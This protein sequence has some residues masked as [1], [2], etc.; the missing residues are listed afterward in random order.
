MCALRCAARVRCA[1]QWRWLVYSVLALERV[2]HQALLDV[3]PLAGCESGTSC[4]FVWMKASEASI[5]LMDAF[6]S[7]LTLVLGLLSYGVYANIG[8]IIWS[9]VSALG[10]RRREP[11]ISKQ[12]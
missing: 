2:L 11:V 7:N 3:N 5:R 8:P 9:R 10:R 12:L 6:A 1:G 4:A